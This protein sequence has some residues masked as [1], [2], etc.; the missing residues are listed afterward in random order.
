MEKRIEKIVDETEYRCSIPQWF[1]WI[2]AGK[3][4]DNKV[5]SLHKDA[6]L[7]HDLHYINQDVSRWHADLKLSKAIWEKD[8][9]FGLLVFP[10]VKLGGLFPWY[11]RKI[12]K[13]FKREKDV[14]KV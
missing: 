3:Q 8:K 4:L 7:D 9:L 10:A 12:K 2:P 13:L 6:C 14:R 1:K 11:G 5:Q